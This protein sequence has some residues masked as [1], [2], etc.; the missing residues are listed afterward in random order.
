MTISDEV[1]TTAHI[2]E[3]EL[4]Q[5]DRCRPVSTRAANTW[6]SEQICG[7]DSPP[8]REAGRIGPQSFSPQT[9]LFYVNATHAYSVYYIYDEANKP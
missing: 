9:G 6:P 5:E 1:L 7:N 2:S 4:R 3:P 8:I